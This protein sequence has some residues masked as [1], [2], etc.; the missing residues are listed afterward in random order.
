MEVGIYEN[1][2]GA[3]ESEVIENKNQERITPGEKS[4]VGPKST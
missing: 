3:G 4:Q 1:S 2:S